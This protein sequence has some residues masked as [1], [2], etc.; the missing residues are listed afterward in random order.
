MRICVGRNLAELQGVLIAVVGHDM[1][2]RRAVRHLGLDGDE[3]AG[4]VPAVKHPARRV[5]S[6]HRRNLLLGG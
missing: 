5:A 3:S 1:H 4:Y 6:E 2:V